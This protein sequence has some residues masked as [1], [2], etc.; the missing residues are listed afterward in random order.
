MVCACV[1]VWACVCVGVLPCSSPTKALGIEDSP[2]TR[3]HQQNTDESF[4]A[5]LQLPLESYDRWR[6]QIL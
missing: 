2:H 3:S 1:Y 5:S 4:R 6:Q